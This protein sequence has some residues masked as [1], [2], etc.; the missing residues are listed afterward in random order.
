MVWIW[1]P[2]SQIVRNSHSESWEKAGTF[3]CCFGRAGQRS[4]PKSFST[5]VTF[6]KALSFIRGLSSSFHYVPWGQISCSLLGR[7]FSALILSF[8][9]DFPCFRLGYVFFFFLIY[10]TRYFYFI[11]EHKL[12]S[13]CFT[14]VL[15]VSVSYCP[16]KRQR[17][18]CFSLRPVLLNGEKALCRR[19]TQK[20]S[21]GYGRKVLPSF[22]LYWL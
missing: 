13:V 14:E 11:A 7:L 1:T 6:S 9:R 8:F 22:H 17:S 20:D 5:D 12:R 21:L 19:D 10:C 18:F 16:I 2:G 4:F 15:W 3:P